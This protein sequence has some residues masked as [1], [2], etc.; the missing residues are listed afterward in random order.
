M[1]FSNV[2]FVTEVFWRSG[3][4]FGF[5]FQCI[6]KLLLWP[7][8]QHPEPERGEKQFHGF[9]RIEHDRLFTFSANHRFYFKKL[10][11][12]NMS[13]GSWINMLYDYN[14]ASDSGNIKEQ[15]KKKD[16][17]RK[18]KTKLTREDWMDTVDTFWNVLL[19]AWFP[20]VAC[21]R[22]NSHWT[23]ILIRVQKKQPMKGKIYSMTCIWAGDKSV[24]T[25]C[26]R[27]QSLSI[28]AC[29]WQKQHVDWEFIKHYDLF[30]LVQWVKTI[31][32][33][34]AIYWFLF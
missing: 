19:L 9:W 27:I 16:F 13:G 23:W 32:Q 34:T 10:E 28:H 24:S 7:A 17:W 21:C 29:S 31:W 5:R 25:Q 20:K 18:Q 8:L 22:S 1:T 30:F 6:I 3:F 4:S 12:A 15:Q 14:R 11:E 2:V 26:F 33:I